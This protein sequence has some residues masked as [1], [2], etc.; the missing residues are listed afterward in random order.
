MYRDGKNY[1]DCV[2]YYTVFAGQEIKSTVIFSPIEELFKLEEKVDSE[3]KG[4]VVR[5]TL[6][7]CFKTKYLKSSVVNLVTYILLCYNF[8]LTG[9]A[10][11]ATRKGWFT[12]QGKCDPQMRDRP[13]SLPVY[14]AGNVCFFCE[15]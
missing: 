3:L 10:P 8:R 9:V 12:L 15:D 1:C 5:R 11:A 4:P 14:T 2:F 13:C 6:I 7:D